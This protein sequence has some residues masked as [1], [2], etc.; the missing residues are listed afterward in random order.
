MHVLY[1][2]SNNSSSSLVNEV[3]DIIIVI[4]YNKRIQTEKEPI[5]DELKIRFN[6]EENK[7]YVYF[8]NPFGSCAYQSDPFTTLVEAEAF[9]QEQLDSAD[10]G[11][12]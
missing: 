4:V 12:E 8:N 2:V 7:Y 1:T 6:E 3:V 5:V 9:K 11:D 10:F